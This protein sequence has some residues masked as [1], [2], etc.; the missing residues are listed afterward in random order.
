MNV[1]T[2]E[3]VAIKSVTIPHNLDLQQKHYPRAGHP[4]GAAPPQHH[5]TAGLP[6]RYGPA[7]D[8]HDFGIRRWREPPG[9]HQRADHGQ[10][11]HPQS[12]LAGLPGR[13]ISPW[14]VHC[15]WWHQ[16]SNLDNPAWEYPTYEGQDGKAVRL[17]KLVVVWSDEGE[18]RN[19]L[20]YATW[21]F[22]G[23]RTKWKSG[24]L[25]VRNFAVWNGF[26]GGA[27]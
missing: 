5:Q 10:E 3:L 16:G 13:Q 11:D 15:S 18:K 1:V 21:S 27:I 14:Q 17:W 24:Y 23:T 26:R 22:P 20:I 12:I 6:C 8:I 4:Q 9:T 7:K 19:S 25:G 2:K